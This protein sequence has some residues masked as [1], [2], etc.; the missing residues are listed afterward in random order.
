MISQTV[1]EFCDFINTN[2]QLYIHTYNI[3]IICLTLIIY[4]GTLYCH[5]GLTIRQFDKVEYYLEIVL[6]LNDNKKYG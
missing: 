3:Y 5:I 4:E 2:I 6:I 1:R